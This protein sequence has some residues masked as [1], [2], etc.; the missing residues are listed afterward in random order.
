[1]GGTCPAWGGK[2]PGG[3]TIWLDYLTLTKGGKDSMGH[4][5]RQ[6]PASAVFDTTFPQYIS[7]RTKFQEIKRGG[8]D[9]FSMQTTKNRVMGGLATKWLGQ[10]KYTEFSE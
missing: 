3:E 9:Y 4:S 2:S 5:R 6:G 7:A 1:V 8:C 10:T